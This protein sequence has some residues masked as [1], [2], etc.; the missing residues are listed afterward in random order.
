MSTFR[1]TLMVRFTKEAT[2]E[3]KQALLDG[4]A[5]LP[6]VIDVIR[7]FEFGLDLGLGD[8]NPDM[9]LVA[10]FDSEADWRTYQEHPAHRVVVED[11][12]APIVRERVRVQYVVD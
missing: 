5:Q 11:L 2:E 4:L 8:A 6:K 10:D 9:A 1:H 3:E 12:V 7:R